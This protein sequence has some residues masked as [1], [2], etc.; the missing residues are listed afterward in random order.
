MTS[1]IDSNEENS[2]YSFRKTLQRIEYKG[3]ITPAKRNSILKDDL[4]ES[5]ISIDS[6]NSLSK[7]NGPNCKDLSHALSQAKHYETVD[8]LPILDN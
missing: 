6:V 1:S 2:E 8:K 5:N 4:N 7:Y 3:G